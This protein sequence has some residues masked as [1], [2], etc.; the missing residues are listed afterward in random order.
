MTNKG[1]ETGEKGKTDPLRTVAEEQLARVNSRSLPDLSGRSSEE[2]IY[3]LRVHQIELE[4]QHEELKKAH[5]EIESSRDRYV[6][7][8]DFAPIGYVTLTQEAIIAESNLT[9]AEMLGI[10]RFHL[11]HR[12][13]REFIAP[14]DQKKWSDFFQ[15]VLREDPRLICDLTLMRADQNHFSARIEGNRIR[16]SQGMM[17]IR[18]AISDNTDRKRAEI[19]EAANFYHRGLIESCIDPFVTISKEGQITDVNQ[20]TEEVTGYSRSELIGTDF[21]DYFTEPNKAHKGY[22]CAF[23]NGQVRDYPLEICHRDGH[24]TPVRYN[25]SVYRDKEGAILGIFAGARDISERKR[26]EEALRESNQK[27][28]LLTSLTRHDIFNHLTA[29]Q[30]LLDLALDATDS[31]KVNE[32]LSY[33][34]E[35]CNRIES[36]IGFTREYENFGVVSSRWEHVYQI[37][38]SAKDEVIFD[39]IQIEN[40]VPVDLKI[41]ADPIIRKVFT[42]FMDNTIRHGGD[43]T[44]IRFS[45]FEHDESLVIVCEDDGIGIPASNKECIFD[46]GF[47]CHTGIGLFLSREILSI[48]GLTVRECGV[49]GQGARFEITVPPGKFRRA[50]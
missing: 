15:V 22:L 42:T 26:M 13:F 9:A 27:L 14:N 30:G 35:V 5:Q 29:V 28:R 33:S 31:A 6:D 40:L 3:E 8:Y 25:A 17:H 34:R 1:T 39:D 46:H 19:F 43:H 21:S 41:Y 24:I 50:V 10:E 44:F 49:E 12:R 37:I 4:I 16:T 18:I 45:V 36:T 38:E 23:Q 48:T 20:A 7:L 11:I 32:Y 47:G 2:I